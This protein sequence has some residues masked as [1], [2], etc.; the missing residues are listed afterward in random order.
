MHI[1]VIIDLQNDFTTG[2]LGNPECCAVIPEV[3]QLIETRSYDAV[4]LTRDSHNEDYLS[5]QEGRRLPVPHTLV[6]TTGW[7]IVSPVSEALR[8]CYAPEQVHYIDKPSFGSLRLQSALLE[9]SKE[10]AGSGLVIDFVGVCTGICVI[11]NAIPAKMYVP[12]AVIRVIERACACVTLQSH[13]TAI[14][15]MRTCQIDII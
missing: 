1:L 14:E 2:V 6:G 7:Q 10:T 15:A 3:V 11:S 5:T 9:L 8:R 4:Y 13:R 12:E